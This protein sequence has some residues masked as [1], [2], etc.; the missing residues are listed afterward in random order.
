MVKIL[1]I[2]IVDEAS[3]RNFGGL[4]YDDGIETVE[5]VLGLNHNYVDGF[6]RIGTNNAVK[7][8]HF[9]LSDDA[10]NKDC[11]QNGMHRRSRLSSGKVVMVSNPSLDFNEVYV[12]P[13]N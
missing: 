9:S 12:E 6:Q 4:C 13:L 2:E 1:S 10:F 8:V 3:Y 7:K 5:E 11:V